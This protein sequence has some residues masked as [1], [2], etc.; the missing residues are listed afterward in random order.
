MK[1]L[2]PTQLERMH[3]FWAMANIKLS[4]EDALALKEW[5]STNHSVATSDWPGWAKYLPT[6]PWKR[7]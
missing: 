6:P 1:A 4:A 5:E 7:S 3:W 2:T